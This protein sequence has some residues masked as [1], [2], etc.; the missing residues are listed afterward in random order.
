MGLAS[1]CGGNFD[2]VVAEL[3]IF[4][5]KIPYPKMARMHEGLALLNIA[6]DAVVTGRLIGVEFETVQKHRDRPRLVTLLLVVKGTDLGFARAGQHLALVWLGDDQRLDTGSAS[7]AVGVCGHGTRSG[8]L[9][10]QRAFVSTLPSLVMSS[11]S[12]IASPFM[13]SRQEPNRAKL[14]LASRQSALVWRKGVDMHKGDEP[15][16]DVEYL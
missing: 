7:G 16:I 10:V 13:A 4:P 8:T 5:G 14:S 3:N 12:R 6:G 11:A 2:G 15:V 1:E 9:S